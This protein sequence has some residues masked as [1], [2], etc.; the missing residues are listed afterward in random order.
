[1]IHEINFKALPDALV[2]KLA[3]PEA[4]VVTVTEPRIVASDETE[5]TEAQE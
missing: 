3:D 2:E 5:T 4:T 1:M